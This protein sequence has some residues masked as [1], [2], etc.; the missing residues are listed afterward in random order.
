MDNIENF[1]KGEEITNAILHGIGLGLAIAALVILVVFASISGDIWD[2]VS[3]SIY[4]VTLVILYL[5]STLYHSFPHGKAKDIFEIFDHSAIYLLIAG[6]YTPLTL[7]SLRGALGWSIFGIVWGIAVI[8]IIFK[9]FW[10]KRFVIFSTI[11]YILMGWIIIF[12]IKPLLS[13]MPKSSLI[14]L[15]VGGG[16]YTVG[17]I[18][19][20]WRKLKY[21]HAI[22]HL[23]VLAGSICHFFTVL[24]LL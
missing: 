5:S 18:F 21:H 6:T 2:I 20:V 19:Y 22:W 14:F 8:G 15:V 3:F 7:I 12:A 9:V 17:T 16:F 24:F 11:L 23:F 13:N 10:V 4:G 1:T